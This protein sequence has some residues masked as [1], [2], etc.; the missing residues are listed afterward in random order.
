[1]DLVLRAIVL[2]A[3]VYLLLRVIG[4]RELA[5]LEPFDF[6]LLIVLGDAIQQGLTQ[7]DYSVSGA[8]IVIFSIA[9]IQVGVGYAAYR[10]RRVR[11][12]I[13]GEPVVLVEDG[14]LI[15][16]NLRRARIA[17]DELAE[18]ARHSQVPS[19]DEVAWAVLETSGRV[20]IIPKRSS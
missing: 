19:L 17:P 13:E 6:I 5:Q 1:M 10:S 12:I 14:R 15:E 9:V 4:R 20:S 2:F 3:A 7:D 11:T 8:I 18:E 16:K